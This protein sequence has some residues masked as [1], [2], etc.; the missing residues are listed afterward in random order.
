[1]IGTEG[2]P[3]LRAAVDA[4]CAAAHIRALGPEDFPAPIRDFLNAMARERGDNA[5]FERAGVPAVF[6]SSGESED[7]HAPTDT[8][9]RLDG[10]ILAARAEAIHGTVLALVRTGRDAAATTGRE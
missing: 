8:P 4:G 6:F 5:S 7:Y 1:M 2:R 3:G 10:A 9:D